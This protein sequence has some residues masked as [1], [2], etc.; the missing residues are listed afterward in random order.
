MKIVEA[1]KEDSNL[2]S[3]LSKALLDFHSRIDR[4]YRPG[5][6]ETERKFKK[7]LMKNIG[8][9]NFKVL[10]IL[11]KTKPIG[12]F[13]GKIETP[14]YYIS[15]QKIGKIE[16]AFLLPEYRRKRIGEKA[17]RK[18]VK[19]FK[20]NKVHCIEVNVDARNKIGVN[21]WKKYGFF[22]FQK[23]LRLDL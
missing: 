22:E 21:A 23:K 1:K 17:F 18:L 10:L 14:P 7:Y 19:W 4:Y 8:K 6:S 12:Y 11:E 13:I 20:K 2:V 9:R 15:V 3:Y 5:D 16:A